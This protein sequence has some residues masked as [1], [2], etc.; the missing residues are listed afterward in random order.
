MT[1]LTIHR[2]SVSDA[3][4]L[5]RLVDLAGEGL[6]SYLWG[7]MKPAGMD[8]WDFGTERAARDTGAFSWRNAWIAEVDGAVAGALVAYDI[9][10]APEP[11]DG[12]P[13]LARPLQALEN[14]VPRSR[15]VNV[16][17]TYP[18][19]RRRG[20]GRALLATQL[21]LA[22]PQAG[23]SIIVAD[24]NAPARA[25]YRAM[26]F[27]VRARRRIRKDGWDCASR[28][29]VLLTRPAPLASPDIIG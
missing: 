3:R 18:A 17:A 20:V 9:A 29:W 1:A 13:P 16:L 15:Y 14:M 19:C 4:H 5:A 7:R 11:L 2:A 21:P 24:R 25:L 28:D 23:L 26:G 12:L 8:V 27:R 6:P 10:A 22:D